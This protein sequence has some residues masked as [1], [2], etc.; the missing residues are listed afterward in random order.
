[1][2]TSIFLTIVLCSF[3]SAQDDTFSV[4][5][6][7]EFL[8][9]HKGLTLEQMEQ[10][11]SAGTF[12]EK[13]EVELST[14]PYLDSIDQ[15]YKL[16]DFEKSLVRQQRFMVTERLRPSTFAQS[17]R[18]I[19]ENDLPVY[20]SSDAI[21]HALHMSYNEILKEVELDYLIPRLNE[22]LSTLYSYQSDLSEKY[23]SNADMATIL[24][25]FDIYVTVAKNLI[26]ESTDPYYSDNQEMVSEILDA[27]VDKSVKAML[28][29]SVHK[30]TIDFSQFTVR[31]HYTDSQSLR[32]YF[33]TMIW[34]G[35]T[36]FY[37]TK[38]KNTLSQQTDEDIRRQV[39]D[40]FLVIEAI[41]NSNSKDHYFE[42]ENVIRRFVGKSDNTDFNTMLDFKEE[43]QLNQASDFLD[44]SNVNLFHD[45]LAGHPG[46]NQKIISQIMAED[47]MKPE[48]VEPAEAFL[49]Y[50]QRYI[51]DSHITGNVVFDKI[52]FNGEQVKRMLPSTLDVLFALGNNAALQLLEGELSTYNYMENLNGMRYIVD[53]HNEDF[54]N[55]SLFNTWLSAIRTLSPPDERTELPPFMQTA[56]WWQKTMNTQLAS[57]TQLRHDNVLYA[58]QS[59]TASWGCFFP[60]AYVEPVPEFYSAVKNFTTNL[61]DIAPFLSEY[62]KG[63]LDTLTINVS[64]IMDTLQNIAQKELNNEGM[65]AEESSFMQRMVSDVERDCATATYEGWYN[66]LYWTGADDD[67]D[68]VVVDIH[69]SPSDE[70]GN[71]VGWV[72][73]A[74]TGPLNTAVIV[75]ELPSGQMMAY[76][77]PVLSY[78]E[79]T[80][81]NYKRLTDEEWQKVYMDPLTMRPDFVN[82]YMADKEGES[83]GSGRTLKMANS[84]GIEP[85]A[86]PKSSILAKNYPNPFNRETVIAFSVNRSSQNHLVDV[87]IYDVQGRVIKTILH[88][89]LPN[90]NYTTRWN[91]LTSTGTEAASGLYF[92]QVKA[93]DLRTTGKMLLTK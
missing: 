40:A 10:M 5:A 65:N 69:T 15:I 7:N 24:K 66:D 1:M 36:E 62:S 50:G 75:S 37:L 84:L 87:S 83:R 68:M 49:L 46:T 13:A 53:S 78:L 4:D 11:Y 57:W 89:N 92:Y 74:G 64:G 22:L 2:R 80:S 88:A 44:S 55:S 79:Y 30:R 59:Y 56:G 86:V 41:E 42:I 93:G 20:V 77:G 21:L 18:Y 6:Y 48:K 31:G 43:Q 73:H 60:E 82:L 90:G 33:K 35:R 38:P 67:R 47:P 58:K 34:L 8:N 39:A 76:I 45:Y 28:L 81:T 14:I 54:W 29:F 52:D 26:D 85:S 72:K 3:L 19:Y 23:T 70:N 17:F 27:I 9:T 61:A 91:G 63:K 16:T 25:D 51:I 71:D 32:K 12:F